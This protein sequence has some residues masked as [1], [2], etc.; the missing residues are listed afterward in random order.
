MR[1]DVFYFEKN[2]FVLPS[3]SKKKLNLFRT[4]KYCSE[5]VQLL[6]IL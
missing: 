1:L 5:I 3:K 2:P 6:E 4:E